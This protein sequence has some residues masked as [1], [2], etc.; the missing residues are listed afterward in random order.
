MLIRKDSKNISKKVTDEDL[1]LENSSKNNHQSPRWFASVCILIFPLFHYESY[2]IT[3][4]LFFI[5]VIRTLFYRFSKH[6]KTVKF[7]PNCVFLVK[8]INLITETNSTWYNYQ[9]TP[10]ELSPHQITPIIKDLYPV[11]VFFFFFCIVF[12]R[13]NYLFFP[14]QYHPPNLLLPLHS[15]NPITT[16]ITSIYSPP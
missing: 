15:G 11:R 5:S 12:F 10:F 9:T 6:Q 7:S 13:P 1:L 3:L 14:H 2:P 16:N 4:Y 8:V